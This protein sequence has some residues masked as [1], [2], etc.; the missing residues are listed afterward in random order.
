MYH[1]GSFIKGQSLI[2]NLDPRV[3]LAATICLSVFILWVKPLTAFVTG[4]ALL[5]AALASGI[6]LRTI[7]QA[8][9][10]LLFFIVLIFLVHAL[11]NEGES[12]YQYS[13]LR[14]F[15]FLCRITT[16]I[17][18]GVAFFVFDYSRG[19]TDDD[20]RAISN[21]CGNKIFSKTAET[22]AGAG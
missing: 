16:G 11:F 1:T 22:A 19:F 3:K 20:H 12:S 17:F 18:C 14:D 8:L 4:S 13:F 21:D 15:S 9:R 10:P 2:Y 6:S 5:F 7:G